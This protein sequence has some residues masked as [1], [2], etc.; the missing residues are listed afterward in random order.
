[1]WL[2]KIILLWITS[3]AAQLLMIVIGNFFDLWGTFYYS[4]EELLH[5]R[6]F[7]YPILQVATIATL[8]APLTFRAFVGNALLELLLEDRRKLESRYSKMMQR[9]WH[10]HYFFTEGF[11]VTFIYALIFTIALSPKHS[12]D[13]Q[14]N[15]FSMFA[16]Y[17]FGLG[18]P[19]LLCGFLEYR[20]SLPILE[21]NQIFENF[22]AD[23]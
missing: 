16:P 11:T 10:Y 21:R 4:S 3:V 17:Y 9:P 6:W 19:L 14:L 5:K 22:G 7:Y 2:L 15:A 1:M 12:P 13:L 18:F 23:D 20:K 8:I